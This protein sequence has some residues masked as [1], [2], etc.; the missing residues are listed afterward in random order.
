MVL[1]FLSWIYIIFSTTNFGYFLNKKLCSKN[2]NFVLINILGLFLI[3]LVASFWAIFGRLNFEFHVFLFSINLIFFSNN[4]LEILKV[5]RR[6]FEEVKH[7]TLFLKFFLFVTSIL[8]IA[9]CSTVP[10]VIDNESY[11]L[12]TIKWINE[13][14]FVKGLVNLHFFLG[15]TSGWHIAQSVFNFSFIYDKFNDLSGYILLLGYVFSVLKLNHFFINK[16]I[17]Y[18][19]VG[20]FP[21]TSLFLFQFISAPSPDV[22]VYV[23][24]FIIF[25]KFIENF[26]KS[27][28]QQFNLILILV[29]FCLFIK[30]T[31]LGLIFIP[32]FLFLQNFRILSRKMF[33]PVLISFVV[34]SLFITK[35]MIICGAPIFPSKTFE[36]FTTNYSIPDTIESFYYDQLKYYGYFLN[37]EQY[38]SMSK[39]DLFFRWLSLPKLNGLFNKIAVILIL[40]L[41]FLIYKFNNVKS[42]WI[43]YFTF[44]IQLILLFLTSP[45]YRFFMNFILFFLLFLLVCF[46]RKKIFINTILILSLVPSVI[47]LLFPINMNSFSNYKFMLKLSNFSVQNIVF[48][49]ENT[50]LNTE[51]EKIKYGNLI[52]NSPK[53]NSFFWASGN[54]DLPC[55][56]KTQIEYFKKY[57]FIVP[58]LR[59]TELKDGLYPKQIANPPTN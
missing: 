7:L 11:Y 8:I 17:N 25:F 42:F 53:D 29:L 56:N 9:T 36:F 48:P 15:Q 32:I 14:G 5:Y 49:H 52:I 41:P 46:I 23:L 45:Q 28:D 51:F 44:I 47:V 26:K 27:D 58:Q 16:N 22:P 10:Y 38:E 24:S 12:Q 19:I 20:L 43:I 2:D 3:T 55:V 18:L 39:M 13:Y 57:F 40:V 34:A 6:F 59:T 54:G 31:S 50:K 35:N 30:N 33:Y 4:R 1:I 37:L 21:I